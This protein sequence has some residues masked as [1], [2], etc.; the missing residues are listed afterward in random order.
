MVI[1][2]LYKINQVD[3]KIRKK[4]IEHYVQYEADFVVH[5]PIMPKCL[6][7][8]QSMRDTRDMSM[9]CILPSNG[10]RISCAG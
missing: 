1:I 5:F 4:P 2:K 6:S 10:L 7:M 9:V 8:I 3:P